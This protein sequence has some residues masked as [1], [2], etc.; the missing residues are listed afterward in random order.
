MK[1]GKRRWLLLLPLAAL[2]A[3]FLAWMY[4]PRSLAAPLRDAGGDIM[5]TINTHTLR[6]GVPEGETYDFTLSPGTAE[7]DALLALL[8]RYSWHERLNTLGGNSIKGSRRGNDGVNLDAQFRAQGHWLRILSYEGPPNAWV[9]H[10]RCQLGWVDDNGELLLEIAELF[11]VTNPP[12]V[13]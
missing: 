1:T 5:V 7:Y 12:F 11:G 4:Y 13:S 3:G 10:N 9:D 2:L 6:A 8:E